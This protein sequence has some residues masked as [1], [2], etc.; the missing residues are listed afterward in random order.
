MRALLWLSSV[1]TASVLAGLPTDLKADDSQQTIY[2]A[3]SAGFALL[4]E[5]SGEKPCDFASQKLLN[6]A[7]SI[8]TSGNVE[9]TYMLGAAPSIPANWPLL[10][11][12]AQSLKGANGCIWTLDV[13]VRA[14]QKGAVVFGQPYGGLVEI[15]NANAFGIAPGN[16]LTA[17][18][19]ETARDS[20]KEL[21]NDVHASRNA[22][23]Q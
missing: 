10:R 18:V 20:L 22:F 23:T 16:G 8:L 21:V 17:Y 13:S 19:S 2:L 3:R 9:F 11:I 15:W 6:D 5:G 14:P 1:V 4:V 12:F 7:E